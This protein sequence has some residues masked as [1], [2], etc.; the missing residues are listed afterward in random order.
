MCLDCAC[1]D[2]LHV[3]PSWKES[4]KVAQKVRYFALFRDLIPGVPKWCPRGARRSQNG[5][6]E[7]ENWP[8]GVPNVASIVSKKCQIISKRCPRGGQCSRKYVKIWFPCIQ[9]YILSKR[10]SNW[11]PKRPN[12]LKQGTSSVVVLSTTCIIRTRPFMSYG[13]PK[14]QLVMHPPSHKWVIR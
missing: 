11:I 1:V 10:A 9:V 7:V 12:L 8:Q 13:F 5:I 14:C 2:G 3:H 4:K 6:H